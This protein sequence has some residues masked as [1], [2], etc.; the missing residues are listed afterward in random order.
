MHKLWQLARHAGEECTD[1]DRV[2]RLF[3]GLLAAIRDMEMTVGVKHSEHKDDDEPGCTWEAIHCAVVQAFE[4][5]MSTLELHPSLL[6][7]VE[8][9]LANVY[10]ALQQQIG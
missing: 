9:L 5:L 8:E 6:D 4:R 3:L 2:N 7:K 1:Q 10:N